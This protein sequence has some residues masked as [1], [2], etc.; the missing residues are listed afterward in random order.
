MIHKYLV[1]IISL[2]NLTLDN[3][4]KWIK[5]R[6]LNLNPTKCKI[7]TIK[8]NKPF[9]PV[10]LI[11]TKITKVKVFKDFEIYISGSLK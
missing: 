7:L 10:D 6:K 11:I 3:I 8:K 9:D 4:Y 5:R 2:F 1:R